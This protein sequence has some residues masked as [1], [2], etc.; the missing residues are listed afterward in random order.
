MRGIW[1]F[2]LVVCHLSYSLSPKGPKE[3]RI[4]SI[5]LAHFVFPP[6]SRMHADPKHPSPTVVFPETR[7]QT[8]SPGLGERPKDTTRTSNSVILVSCMSVKLRPTAAIKA[9]DPGI[10][11]LAHLGPIDVRVR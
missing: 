5:G 10:R 2:G 8:G 6:R 4:R 3:L 11:I 9:L 1:L 7:D